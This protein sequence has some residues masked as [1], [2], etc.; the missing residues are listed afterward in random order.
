MKPWQK[1]DNEEKRR[2]VTGLALIT[3]IGISFAVTIGGCIF[4]GKIIDDWLH[5]SPWFLLIFIVLGVGAAFRN[6][7]HMTKL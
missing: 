1:F 7:F 6:L 2:S 5:T 3:Q 4:L